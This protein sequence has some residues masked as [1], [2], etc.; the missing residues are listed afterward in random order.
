MNTP[1]HVTDEQIEQLWRMLQLQMARNFEQ[2][3]RAAEIERDE[4]E[5]Y[6]GYDPRNH[7]GS[8]I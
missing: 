7:N 4:R 2:A 5:R 8:K 1:Y 6:T 3:L